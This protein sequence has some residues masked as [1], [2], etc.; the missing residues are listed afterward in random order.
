MR[1]MDEVGSSIY[2]VDLHGEA[3][4]VVLTYDDGPQPG[5]TEA[6]LAALAA[7][8]ATATFFVLLTRVRRHPTLLADVAAAGHEIGLHG[9][10]HRRL[11]TV[12]PATLQRRTVDGRDELQDALGRAVTWFRPPYGDQSPASWRA[13][14]EAGMTPV[15]W[16]ATLRD[17][18]DTTT[19]DR[20]GAASRI[21]GPGAILLAHDG[22][23]A[24]DD[25]VDDGPAPRFDRGRLA[26]LVLDSYAQ[27]GLTCTSLG[28][29]L[30]SGSPVKR[31]W[32]TPG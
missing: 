28:T 9:I 7:A 17:W 5:D 24:L 3:R 11:T 30:E 31:V 22:Y 26:T 29:A 1:V 6:V 13:V 19:E 12:D 18:L 10:D 21:D 4:H 25:G 23:A 32:W 14:T 20:L 16:S 2:E 15:M 8:G 27:Q